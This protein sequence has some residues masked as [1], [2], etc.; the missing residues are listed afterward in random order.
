MTDAL[1]TVVGG[2][3][4]CAEC[5]HPNPPR[6]GVS[7]LTCEA[8]GVARRGVLEEPLDL[9]RRPA[10]AEVPGTWYAL[11]WAVMALLGTVLLFSES[12]RAAVGLG[13]TWVLL[14]VLGATYAAGSSLLSAAWDRWFNE[15]SLTTPPHARTGDAFTVGLRLVP[16]VRLDDVSVSLSFLDRYYERSGD[17]GVGTRTQRLARHV[18]LSGGTLLGRR[19]ARFEATF[20]A[21]FPTR[22]HT[23]VRAEI[24]ADVMDVVGFLVPAA[25][26]NAGNL[27]EHGGFVVEASV[28]VGWV[29]RRLVR[30]VFVYYLGDAVH[31]G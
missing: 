5:G 24:A 23:D 19:E 12:A 2:A 15:F 8:C 13:R 18:L 25:R 3:W 9:P 10:W 22:K 7:G 26:W 1:N 11:G 14:E 31:V 4:L 6:E 29:P 30:R 17:S 27:R 21:P 16:Y 20:L 28:R